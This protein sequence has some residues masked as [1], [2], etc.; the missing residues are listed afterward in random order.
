MKKEKF[1]AF[2]LFLILAIAAI[3]VTLFKPIPRQIGLIFRQEIYILPLIFLLALLPSIQKSAAWQAVCYAVL[4]TVCLLPLSGLW[5]SGISDQYIF[6]SSIPWSDAFTHHLNTLR[7]LY[8]QTMGQSTAVRPLSVSFYSFILYITNN[9]FIILMSSLA[10]LSAFV[11]LINFRL[12]GI[13][14]GPVAAA[15]FFTN[16]FFFIRKFLGI[17]MTEPYAFII[18]LLACYFL[19]NGIF[20]KQN[21]QILLGFCLFSLAMNARPGPMFTI[22]LIGLW[23]FFIFLKGHHRRIICATVAFIALLSGFVINQW[24][25]NRV[26]RSD[27][28]PNLQAAQIIYGLCLGGKDSYYV[29]G[30]PEIN[31]LNKSENIYKDVFGLCS[32][33]L[34]EHPEN[35]GVSF[36]AIW[37]TLLFDSNRGSF[38]YFDGTENKMLIDLI[39]MGLM[40]LWSIGI[41]LIFRQ[42][43]QPFGS[44]MIAMV[45]GLI[46][47]QFVVAPYTTFRMRYH[48]ATIWVPGLIIGIFPQYVINRF[49]WKNLK[50]ESESTPVTGSTSLALALS[51]FF[52]LI[53]LIA[54][55]L[56]GTRPL[57]PP[58]KPEISC[59][60]G[61]TTLYTK[62]DQGSYFYME[63][64]SELQQEHYPYF[65]L[66][67]VRQHFHDT[68]SVEMFDF[69]DRIDQPTAII[70]GIDL[71]DWK[72]A[73]IF[74]P[75]P[76]VKDRI[77]Y[78]VFCGNYLDPP[79]L[80]QDR[81]FI[82]SSAYFLQ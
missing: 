80:R 36:N 42:R 76:L 35:I 52:I 51:G 53:A 71:S 15:F 54:P 45:L 24:N 81:F 69:T 23:Y 66:P 38:S 7:F 13:H 72:D 50:R 74:S 30:L 37:N 31:E 41:F 60:K 47:S 49:A 68:A 8:G 59:K 14:I 67:F 2:P 65:R 46:L 75:L 61:E 1:I 57:K 79:I 78:V 6:G 22:P 26:Y 33:V 43:K 16:A 25:V 3:W 11:M 64:K 27:K 21:G 34:K 29:M 48:A 18:G 10:V 39:R 82:P 44:F 4:F 12:I 19:L 77:G 40:L 58:A 62:I 70:R 28:V 55:E 56:I 32:N 73:L 5:N 63:N 9:N 17:Y 20:K